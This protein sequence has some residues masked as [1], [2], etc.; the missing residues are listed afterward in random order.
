MA[1][2]DP[3]KQTTAPTDLT[4]PLPVSVPADTDELDL[5]G[6]E[7]MPADDPRAAE[8]PVLLRGYDRDAVDA[9]VAR[10]SAG[11]EELAA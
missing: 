6:R 1:D 5:A 8:F 11:I 10:V 3:P 9:Y 7:A 4:A 2:N